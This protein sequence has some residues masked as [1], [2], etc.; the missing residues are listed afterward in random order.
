MQPPL[1]HS[2]REAVARGAF[3]EANR[4]L[5]EYCEQLRTADELSRAKELLEWM[6]QRTQA[7]RA[8]DAA[9][10]SELM[11]AMQYRQRPVDRLHTWQIDG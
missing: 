8:H 1:E 3:G 9:R 7:A 4:L 5:P 2:I 6:L 10:L 11:S